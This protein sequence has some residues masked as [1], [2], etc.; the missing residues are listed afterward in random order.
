MN[1]NITAVLVLALALAARVAVADPQ[2]G[3]YVPPMDP[4]RKVN[5]QDCTKTIQ[6]D[7]RGNLMCIELSE[8]QR[9]ALLAEQERQAKARREAEER[10]AREKLE[11]IGRASCRERVE[12][13]EREGTVEKR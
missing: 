6:T 5:E 10:A 7:G 4:K 8:R 3:V 1:K 11:Q 13:W 2:D 9:R 12:R